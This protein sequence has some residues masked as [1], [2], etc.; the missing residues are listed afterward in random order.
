VNPAR[1]IAENQ[2][3]PVQRQITPAPGLL[4]VVDSRA[5][6]SAYPATQAALPQTVNLHHD[7]LGLVFHG[8]HSMS[9]QFQQFPDKGFQ[10]HLVSTSSA[11]FF[12]EQRKVADSKCFFNRMLDYKFS[13]RKGL[14]S[15]YTFGRRA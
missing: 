13:T 9:F 5:G 12:G 8:G 2:R 6:L 14:R 3:Q 11:S 10:Q 15:F 1:A 4:H 7:S